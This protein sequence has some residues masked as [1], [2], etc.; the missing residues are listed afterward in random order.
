MGQMYN[1]KL[2]F[3]AWNLQWHLHQ[4]NASSSANCNLFHFRWFVLD[5]ESRYHAFS[6]NRSLLDC[7]P[8]R[9]VERMKCW[10]FLYTRLVLGANLLHSIR[11]GAPVKLQR[12]AHRRSRPL[13][14][15]SIIDSYGTFNLQTKN[16]KKMTLEWTKTF[17]SPM[18]S[19][20]LNCRMIIT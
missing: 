5:E 15:W 8:F 1:I 11:T 7:T 6:A 19:R 18:P 16:N 2:S 10:K 14:T 17:L 9:V 13:L 20:K 12:P 4:A 3:L